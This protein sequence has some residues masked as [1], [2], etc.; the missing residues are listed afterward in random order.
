[1]LYWASVFTPVL[2]SEI[3]VW[4]SGSEAAFLSSSACLWFLRPHGLNRDSI[5]AKES[6]V[7]DCPSGLGK[8]MRNV[9]IGKDSVLWGPNY[10]GPVAI[11]N[12]FSAWFDPVDEFA[13]AN[14]LL[15]LTPQMGH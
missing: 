3:T 6:G 8:D 4:A 9:V 7:L 2:Y 11:A 5:A 10:V 15:I 13:K 12:D 1:M 14:T